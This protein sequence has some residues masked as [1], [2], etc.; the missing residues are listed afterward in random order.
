MAD[1]RIK[2]RSGFK[3]PAI[4]HPFTG[5]KLTGRRKASPQPLNIATAHH[6]AQAAQ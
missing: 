4:Q 3:H 5:W 2:S 1:T 6:P